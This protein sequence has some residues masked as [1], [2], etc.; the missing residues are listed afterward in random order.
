MTRHT[1]FQRA[2]VTLADRCHAHDGY[3]LRARARLGGVA[4]RAFGL[5]VLD[6]FTARHGTDEPVD[7]LMARS[8]SLGGA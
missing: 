6:E 8:V 3:S 5:A 4:V 1:P 7:R 2:H